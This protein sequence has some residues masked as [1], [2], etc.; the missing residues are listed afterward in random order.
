MKNLCAWLVVFVV[1]ALA[2]QYSYQIRKDGKKISPALS[3]WIIFFLGTG[4]SFVTYLI[5]A[6]FDFRSGI[7]NTMDFLSVTTILLSIILWGKRDGK[8]FQPFEKWYLAGIGAIV[9]YGVLSH[10][11]WNSNIFTQVLIAA[12]YFPTVH[13]MVTEKRNTESYS[14]W[15]LA[16]MAGAIGLYPAT[17]DGNL[18]AILY[19]I[20]TIVLVSAVLILMTHYE[21]R[22]RR[23]GL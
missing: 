18:L 16:L 22:L 17:V 9:V 14:M 1:T 20:R 8:R 2:A 19:A 15:S 13:K 23:V 10:D 4:L 5:A 21:F 3:T 12:G 6:K 7:L 11:A